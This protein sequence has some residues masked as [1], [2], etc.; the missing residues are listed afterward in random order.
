MQEWDQIQLLQKQIA[1]M[2]RKKINK[3]TTTTTTIT[4]TT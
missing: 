2:V 1:Q 3:T 4:T